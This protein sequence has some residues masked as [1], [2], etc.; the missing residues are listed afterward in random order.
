MM[1]LITLMDEYISP[2]NAKQ[3]GFLLSPKLGSSVHTSYRQIED[4]NKDKKSLKKLELEIGG[5]G[6]RCD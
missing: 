6:S 4:T 2:C 1:G 5:S 3:T